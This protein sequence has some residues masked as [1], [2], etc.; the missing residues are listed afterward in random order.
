MT[1]PPYKEQIRGVLRAINDWVSLQ[2]IKKFLNATPAEYRYIN[3]ALRKGVESGYFIKNGGK[4]RLGP[5][6]KPKKKIM[7]TC[8][9]EK[10]GEYRGVGIRD[11]PGSK[12]RPGP[13]TP[14]DEEKHLKRRRL[15][16]KRT[17]QGGRRYECVKRKRS[18]RK[19]SKK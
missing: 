16:K 15:S 1:T 10:G 2:A 14:C 17:K 4:Y 18:R 8:V 3:D 6:A 13:R 5:E 9:L 11:P 7:K 19:S 12:C